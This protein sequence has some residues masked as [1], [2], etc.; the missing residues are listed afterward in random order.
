MLSLRYKANKPYVMYVYAKGCMVLNPL[1]PQTEVI[2]FG[3]QEFIHYGVLDTFGLILTTCVKKKKRRGNEGG[4]FLAPIRG[5]GKKI[6]PFWALKKV[7]RERATPQ[8]PPLDLSIS[9]I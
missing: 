2:T 9:S 5:W 1:S 7:R 4:A 6:E 3:P 8:P